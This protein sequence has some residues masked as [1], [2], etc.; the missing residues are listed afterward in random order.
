MLLTDIKIDTHLFEAL[1]ATGKLLGM[2]RSLAS[3]FAVIYSQDAPCT[4][5][6][7]ASLS[8]LSKSAVSLALRDLIL[9]GAAQELGLPGERCRRYC[10]Q[11]HLAHTVIHLIA[12]RLSSP[13]AEIQTRLGQA[14]ETN[15]R[16]DQAR[17]LVNAMDKALAQLQKGRTV[18]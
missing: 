5:E 10:G 12:S 16:L 18:S 17:E 4:V 1:L 8:N 6:E 9:L 2:N 15:S 14:T 3:V 11:P 13:L 7:I